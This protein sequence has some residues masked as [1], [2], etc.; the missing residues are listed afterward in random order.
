MLEEF[1]SVLKSPTPNDQDLLRQMQDSL[2]NA[3]ETMFPPDFDF[4]EVARIYEDHNLVLN[5]HLLTAQLVET[6]INLVMANFV[7]I[8]SYQ[9]L[10]GQ[11]QKQ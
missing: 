7:S 6:F 5:P 8:H 4:A 10:E 11:T 3:L 2:L 9:A 1:Q